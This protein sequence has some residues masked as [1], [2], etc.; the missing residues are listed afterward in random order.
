M[1]FPQLHDVLDRCNSGPS[2]T[3]LY[4]LRSNRIDLLRDRDQ[5]ERSDL[6]VGQ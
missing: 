1:S 6:I 3:S 5:C 4:N 2:M